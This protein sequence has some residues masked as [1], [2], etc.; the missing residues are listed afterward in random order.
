MERPLPLR[1]RS[2]RSGQ[3]AGSL[4][5]ARSSPGGDA[6]GDVLDFLRLIWAVDHALSRTS[7]AMEG[8]LGVTA[9]QRVVIRIIGRFP[10]I[11]AGHVAR[12]LHIHPGTLSGILR[13]IER[14]GLVSRRSDAHDG[15]R[16]LL[17]LTEKGRLLDVETPGTVEAAVQQAL[18]GASAERIEAAREML[19]AIAHHLD[20]FDEK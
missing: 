2:R 11:P 20:R 19:R 17:G 5:V 8:A 6:L 1:R 13:R 18:D 4:P 3:G 15:R 12:L 7:R 14:R 10:G 9:Q 16:T